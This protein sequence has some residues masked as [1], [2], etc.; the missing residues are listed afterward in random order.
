[1]GAA[2]SP[3]VRGASPDLWASGSARAPSPLDPS[4]PAPG[5]AAAGAAGPSRGAASE[6][7]WEEARRR[8][9]ALVAC[10][11]REGRLY[12]QPLPPPDGAA[13][14]PAPR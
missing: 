7:V 14:A 1:M 9:A 13:Q 4:G 3:P 10:V 12:P 2:R 8:A 6:A 5:R 11:P